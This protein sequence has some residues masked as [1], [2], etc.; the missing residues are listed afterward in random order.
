ML[1]WLKA[2]TLTA[3]QSLQYYVTC[4]EWANKPFYYP[5]YV[6]GELLY[7]FIYKHFSSSSG[8][9]V[10]RPASRFGEHRY[11][12]QR[13][14]DNGFSYSQRHQGHLVLGQQWGEDYRP[15]HTTPLEFCQG[16]RGH[17]SPLIETWD[18]SIKT[19]IGFYNDPLMYSFSLL[20]CFLL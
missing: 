20:L 11:R 1:K 8:A 18:L 17:S 4:W 10:F 15:T 7:L 5:F 12:K 13:P 14:A 2:I 16:V 3:W 19:Q 9:P 6:C